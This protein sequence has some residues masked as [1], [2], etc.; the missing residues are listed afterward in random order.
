MK[1][2]KTKVAKKPKAVK[3]VSVQAKSKKKAGSSNIVLTMLTL[4]AVGITGYFCWQYIKRKGKKAANTSNDSLFKPQQDNISLPGTDSIFTPPLSPIKNPSTSA[5]NYNPIIDTPV[6]IPIKGST[7]ANSNN[8][9]KDSFPLKKGSK[10]ER[11]R[12]LQQSLINKNGAS[13]LPRYG[14]DGSFGSEVISALKKLKLPSTVSET[15]YNVLTQGSNTISAGG[16]DPDTIGKGIF[17]STQKKDLNTVIS[18]LKQINNVS[19]Y[20]LVN[21]KFQEYRLN[22]GVRKTL[23]NGILSTFLSESQ[24]SQIR[25]EF[26]R[27][28]LRYDGSKWSLSGLDGLTIATKEPAT[29]W[30]NGKKSITVPAKMVL[31]VEVSR[32]LDY[33]LFENN[34]K[35][36]LVQTRSVTYM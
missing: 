33:T 10:G 32:R 2:L 30:I 1:T 28:G 23:V 5:G 8:T 29:I 18:F 20:Q 36:F 11:V 14:A 13:I 35:Y 4:G 34:K 3:L 16:F 27:M 15:L 26:V 25:Y 31:G 24:K 6:N 9:E 21:T 22:G 7:Q 12:I 19:E 17:S